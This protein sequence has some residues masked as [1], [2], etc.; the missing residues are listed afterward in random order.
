[1]S[2]PLS[3]LTSTCALL[4]S[5][6]PM[7][8][9]EPLPDP[10]GPK[11]FGSP[12][13][14]S[15]RV[16]TLRVEAWARISFCGPCPEIL[17][18]WGPP[19]GPVLLHR[20]KDPRIARPCDFAAQEWRAENCARPR[21]FA[22]LLVNSEIF[23]AQAASTG[24]ITRDKSASTASAVRCTDGLDQSVVAGN[25]VLAA[26]ALTVLCA[27]MHVPAR[28]LHSST[29]SRV[30]AV[31]LLSAELSS[32]PWPPS[33][34]WK[35]RRPSPTFALCAS[36]LCGPTHG[37]ARPL[38]SSMN[39]VPLPVC[40]RTTSKMRGFVSQDHIGGFSTKRECANTHK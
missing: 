1:V 8:A 21:D 6:N 15:S 29:V 32:L 11:P 39:N 40:D 12:A 13:R 24:S 34:A 22:V 37:S 31:P 10:P 36:R 19:C 4:P 14:R 9:S 16:P 30:T 27:P 35:L 20:N 25:Q 17:T 5:P 2:G 7:G 38:S 26:A 18:E 28:M 33:R 23:S 3:Y